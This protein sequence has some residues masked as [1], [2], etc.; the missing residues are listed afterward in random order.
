[1]NTS[2]FNYYA[3]ASAPWSCLNCNTVNHSTIAYEIPLSDCSSVGSTYLSVHEAS[4][5]LTPN[6]SSNKSNTNNQ[7]TSTSSFG[8]PGAT[9]SPKCTQNKPS[10]RILNINF[11]SIRKIGLNIEILVDTTSPD[12]IIGTET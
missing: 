11:K 6:K 3:N 7:D 2:T 4:E 12:T 5:I 9:S 1:M 8:S 10:L